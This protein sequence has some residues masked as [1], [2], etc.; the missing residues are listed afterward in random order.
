MTIQNCTNTRGQRTSGRK[1][2]RMEAGETNKAGNGYGGWA[3]ASLDQREGPLR[4][5]V[6]GCFA[7]SQLNS[8]LNSL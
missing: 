4:A 6:M 7:V 8:L 3:D 1:R 2:G 5:A